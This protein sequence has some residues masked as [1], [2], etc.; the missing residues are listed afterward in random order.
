MG[1]STSSESPGVLSWASLVT[2]RDH[3]Q[4]PPHNPAHPPQERATGRAC[5]FETTLALSLK[6]TVSGSQGLQLREVGAGSQ[7]AAPSRAPSANGWN[8]G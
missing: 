4:K 1:G 2:G 7:A 8:G 3:V 5:L 6:D